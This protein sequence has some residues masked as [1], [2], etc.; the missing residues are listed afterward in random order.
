MSEDL[1]YTVYSKQS[2]SYRDQSSQSVTFVLLGLLSALIWKLR[3]SDGGEQKVVSTG[4]MKSPPHV[5]FR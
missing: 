3:K 1:Q 4:S 2:P 5:H